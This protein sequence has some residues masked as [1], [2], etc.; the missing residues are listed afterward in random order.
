MA[1]LSHAFHSVIQLD[2]ND[3]FCDAHHLL[4]R[5]MTPF[6]PFRVILV[7]E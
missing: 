2:C 3:F 7:I 5:N 4:V 1:V 6:M